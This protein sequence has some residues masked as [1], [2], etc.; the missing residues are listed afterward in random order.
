MTKRDL[1]NR[2]AVAS[3]LPKTHV[4]EVLNLFLDQVVEAL[5][6]EG[7]VGFRNFG[8]FRTVELPA[9]TGR[10]PH[11]GE[12]VEIPARRHVRFK[13]GKGMRERINE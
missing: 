5:A 11:T 2:I 7:R 1:V 6:T 3:G 9:R 10:N 12:P 13:A 4:H 8:S